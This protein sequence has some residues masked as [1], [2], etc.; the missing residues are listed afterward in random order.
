MRMSQL[1]TRTLR[2]APKDEVALNAILLTRAGFVHKNMAGVYTILPL[3]LR[4]L[5]KIEQIV[6]DEMNAIGGQE[7]VMNAL[8]EKHIWENTGRWESYRGAMYQFRD[9]GGQEIGLA[10]THEE[11]IADIATRFIASYR[12]LP[13]AVYQFQTKYRHE[14]RPRSGLLRGREFRMKDLY[15]FH[16]SPADL[17]RYYQE[18]ARAYKKIFDRVGVPTVVAEASGGP[19]SSEPSHEFQALAAS[20]EDLIHYCEGGEVAQNREVY[21]GMN[22]CPNGHLIKEA[23]AIEVGN[24]FK[25]GTRYSRALGLFFTDERGDKQPVVMASYGIGTTRLMATC[26][27]LYHDERGIRWPPSIA[28]FHVHLARLGTQEKVGQAADRLYEI[29][30]EAALAVLYDDRDVQA[31]EKFVDAD[32]IGIPWRAVISDKTLAKHA[33]ELKTRDRDAVE[34]VNTDQLIN[35]LRDVHEAGVSRRPPTRA[36]TGR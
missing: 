5:Q 20:G 29:L 22:R 26:V 34:L 21:T 2:Q 23:S 12:D 31:G 4:V 33:L 24:I 28:P 6:R 25:L 15:S 27:E 10:P 3:G 8:Q 35:R 13:K 14:V 19:F 1:F 7:L 18:V 36:S 30:Q 16:A 17:D 9:P 11:V 32:L